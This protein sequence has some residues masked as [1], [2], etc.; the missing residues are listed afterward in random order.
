MVVVV[1]FE[2]MSL[3]FEEVLTFFVKNRKRI[4]ICNI[5]W[6]SGIIL[7]CVLWRTMEFDGRRCSLFLEGWCVCGKGCIDIVVVGVSMIFDLGLFENIFIDD[8]I[9]IVSSLMFWEFL[10]TANYLHNFSVRWVGSRTVIED[11]LFEFGIHG[12]CRDV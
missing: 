10:T 12:F 8:T 11:T 1:A 2:L 5:M 9:T 7:D 6:S 3:V 4:C